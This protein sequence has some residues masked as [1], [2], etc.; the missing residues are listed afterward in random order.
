MDEGS[1]GSPDI[2]NASRTDAAANVSFA[3]TDSDSDGIQ[4]TIER[5]TCADDAK[6]TLTYSLFGSAMESDYTCKSQIH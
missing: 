2:F 4:F 3:V 5:C 1:S 6:A